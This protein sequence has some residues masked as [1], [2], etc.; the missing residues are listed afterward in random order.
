M[1][2]RGIADTNLIE[3]S[4][5]SAEKVIKTLRENNIYYQSMADIDIAHRL[6]NKNN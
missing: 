6:P 3:T 1:K 4:R 5:E 2:I